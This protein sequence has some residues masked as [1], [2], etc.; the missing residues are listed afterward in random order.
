MS[1][2]VTI[3]TTPTCGYCK[4]AKAFFQENEVAYTEINVAADQEKAKE[5]IQRSGQMGVPV[6]VVGEGDDEELVVGF[7]QPHLSQLLGIGA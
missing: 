7:N 1:K 6:I 2:P 5:M 3:Y 4:A